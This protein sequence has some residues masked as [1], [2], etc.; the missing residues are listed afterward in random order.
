[1]RAVFFLLAFLSLG[2]GKP[3]LGGEARINKCPSREEILDC[4]ARTKREFSS[5]CRQTGL[6]SCSAYCGMCDPS[7]KKKAKQ[8]LNK[9]EA[10]SR[11]GHANSFFR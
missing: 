6:D 8:N 2:C 3:N 11:H 1:M 5:V 7:E 4:R 10:Q 9:R